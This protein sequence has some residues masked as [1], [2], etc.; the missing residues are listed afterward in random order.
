MKR[1]LL[2]LIS[3]IVAGCSSLPLFSSDV[4]PHSITEKETSDNRPSVMTK[5]Q[6]FDETKCEWAEVRYVNDGDTLQLRR[7]KVRVIGIDTPEIDGPHTDAEHLGLNAS[8][9]AR[10]LINRGDRVCLLSTD[11]QDRDQYDR[12]LRYVHLADGRDFGVLMLETGLAEIYHS[13][14]H[15]RKK[16]YQATERAAKNAQIGLWQ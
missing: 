8:A 12:L 13:Q 15:P 11:A 16:A 14:S 3:I 1:F 6:N 5:N 9:F 4:K 7:E 10:S 2:F